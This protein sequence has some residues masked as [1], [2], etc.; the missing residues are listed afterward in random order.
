MVSWYLLL[1]YVVKPNYVDETL[2]TENIP[3]PTNC[4]RMLFLL[5]NNLTTIVL[6]V[7][8]RSGRLSS[9]AGVG[10]VSF[11]LIRLLGL[12]GLLMKILISSLKIH[13]NT[14]L[15]KESVSALSKTL[16]STICLLKSDRK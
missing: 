15:M 3:N 11:R 10:L 9:S 2:I 16:E 13:L 12:L 14:N 8:V 6:S 1:V 7:L 5:V 4:F